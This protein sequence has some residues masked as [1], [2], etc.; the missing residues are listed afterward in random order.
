MVNMIQQFRYLAGILA[1][2]MAVSFVATAQDAGAAMNNSTVNNTTTNNTAIDNA[3]AGAKSNLAQVSSAATEVTGT[4][5]NLDSSGQSVQNLS[6]VNGKTFATASISDMAGAA[7]LVAAGAAS[8]QAVT[9]PA[10]SYKIGTGVGGIDPFNPKH[11]DIT[12]QSLDIATKP[13]RD[14]GKMFFVCDIV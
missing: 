2:I 4:T 7:P 13:I 8:A 1:V 12:P 5:F 11:A 3:S 9:T 14:T 10:N 6:T